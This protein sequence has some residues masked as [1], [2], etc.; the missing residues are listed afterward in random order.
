MVNELQ[1]E[2]YTMAVT[3]QIPSGGSIGSVPTVPSG[4]MGGARA[5]THGPTGMGQ[6][7]EGDAL[8]HPMAPQAKSIE[9]IRQTAPTRN[10]RGGHD[11]KI[12]GT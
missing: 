9:A 10:G 6:A 12:L 8:A 11:P 2:N 4:T 1:K 5:G 3:N 7:G